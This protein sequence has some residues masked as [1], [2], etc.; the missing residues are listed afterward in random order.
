MPFARYHLAKPYTKKSARRTKS[1]S[2]AKEKQKEVRS[3]SA[4]RSS[5][6]TVTAHLCQVSHL[7]APQEPYRVPT[8]F[9]PEKAKRRLMAERDREYG[10]ELANVVDRAVSRI[11][12]LESSARS[13]FATDAL[14]K[15][16]FEASENRPSQ[17]WQSTAVLARPLLL[18]T[19][20]L[21]PKS[22]MEI[23]AASSVRRRK[24]VYVQ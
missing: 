24:T 17:R 14:R 6:E 22:A 16:R 13:E 11:R 15:V 18:E 19:R 23:D 2:S 21:L 12:R 10:E 9:S 7:E 20:G 4:E 3:A 5:G 1:K 8:W